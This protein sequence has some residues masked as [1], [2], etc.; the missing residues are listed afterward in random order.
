M[1]LP[2]GVRVVLAPNPGPMTGPGTN[3]Y[4]VGFGA[5]APTLIDAAAFDEEN[6]RRFAAETSEVGA[7]VLTHTHPDHVGGALAV[8]ETWRTSIAVHRSHAHVHVPGGLLAPER[9]LEHEDEIHVPGGRLVAIHTPG[10]HSGHVCFYEPDRRWLFT[11]DTILSTGTT[12]IAPP[13]GDMRDY[14]ASLRRLQQLDVAVIFPAH[15]PPIDRPAEVIAEYI[16][17]RLQ[18]EQQVRDMLAAGV[19]TPEAMVPRIY[20][21]LH[22]VLVGAAAVQ[23]RAH[24][25]KLVADG[26][27]VEVEPGRFR[28]A[29]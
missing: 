7:L 28:L 5:D 9:T 1:S 12:V 20:P 8:R 3:Q 16:A 24:L 6:R 22:P 15:G 29:R 23:M 18:R 11:G 21:E 19:E 13:D 2:E 17:H 26:E 25:T 4:L 10:H 14:M 27:V